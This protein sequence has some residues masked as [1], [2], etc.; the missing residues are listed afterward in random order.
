MKFGVDHKHPINRVDLIVGLIVIAIGGAAAYAASGYGIGTARRMGAGFF[1]LALGLIAMGLGA[2]M[3]ATAVLRPGPGPDLR[4]DPRQFLFVTAA[5]FIF[6]IGIDPLGAPLTVCL[7]TMI[8]CFGDRRATLVEA[9]TLGLGL[10]LAIWVIFVQMLGL[11]LPVWPAI[12]TA[13][14]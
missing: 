6:A 7:A 9:V 14:P 10:A 12:L 2:L 4:I 13:A 5:F 11:A 1:P 3:S 8:A